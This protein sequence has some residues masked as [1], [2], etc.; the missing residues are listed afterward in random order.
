MMAK[1]KRIVNRIRFFATDKGRLVVVDEHQYEDASIKQY[2]EFLDYYVVTP[3]SRWCE[4]QGTA[5]V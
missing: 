5:D 4:C 2:V 3:Q 1:R